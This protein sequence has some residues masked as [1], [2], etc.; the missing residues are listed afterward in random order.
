[1]QI[2]AALALG[3]DDAQHRFGGGQAPSA[4]DK[5]DQGEKG[6]HRGGV[7]GAENETAAGRSCGGKVR[8]LSAEAIF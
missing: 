1:L 5:D 2:E 6:A 4:E 7:V 3:H 8:A